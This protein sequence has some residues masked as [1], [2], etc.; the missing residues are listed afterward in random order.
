MPRTI[1]DLTASSPP[2]DL[3]TGSRLLA[4]PVLRNA[5]DTAPIDRLRLTLRAIC[6]QSTTASDTARSL[7]LTSR[8]RFNEE[9]TAISESI[10]DEEEEEED[11]DEEEEDED[12][13]R[14]AATARKRKIP[15]FA[16]C[17][18]CLEDF[19]ANAKRRKY[20]CVWHPGEFMCKA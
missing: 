8:G 10:A 5:I 14:E 6:S 4:D 15:R 16:V 18:I 20:E 19:D 1:V 7:L 13:E 17:R 12:D 2:C 3:S 11:E 9:E